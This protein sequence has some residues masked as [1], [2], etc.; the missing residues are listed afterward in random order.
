MGSV[1]VVGK[2]TLYTVGHGTRTIEELGEVLKEA[3]V[4]MLIDVR[5]YPGSRRHPHFAREA[6]EESVPGGGILYEW[7]GQALGGRREARPDSPNVAWRVAAFRGYADHL[8]TET[9]RAALGELEER[10]AT[11]RQ[12]V[13]CAETLWWRCHRRLIADS[14]VADGYEVIHLGIGR[15]QRHN[16]HEAARRT[17]EGVL[18]YDL[19]FSVPLGI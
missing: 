19:G 1:G 11:C 3:D 15:A 7:R 8:G 6:L 13:M 17:E 14:L 5:R 18:V 12:A 2:R 16:L 9:F 10:A 4:E